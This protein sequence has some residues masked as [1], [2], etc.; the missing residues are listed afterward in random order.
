M[1]S[2]RLV[3]VLLVEDEDFTRNL[4]SDALAHSNF[5]VRAVSSIS[6]AISE[7]DN[8][9][10]NVVVTD[11]DF[12]DGPDGS[13]LV[14]KISTEK[15]WIG[16]VILSAHTSPELAV[17]D[18]TR[19]PEDTVYIVKSHISSINE[20]VLGINESI[21]KSGDYESPQQKTGDY[22]TVSSSQGEILKMLAEGLTNSAIAQSK[23]ISLRA[24]E[25]LIQRTFQSLDVKND[26]NLNPRVIASRMWQQGKVIVK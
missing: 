25:A 17:K 19:I 21:S 11:L 10:P 5:A 3:K 8:F 7:L 15:P 4:I 18:K 16:I 12:G 20:L 1:T 26:P 22:K 24:A 9:D 6:E 14:E 23:G 2:S 13:D